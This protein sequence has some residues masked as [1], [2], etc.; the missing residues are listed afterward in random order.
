MCLVILPY[1]ANQANV[2]SQTCVHLQ[3]QTVLVKINVLR[4]TLCIKVCFFLVLSIKITIQV[5]VTYH[6]T[7]TKRKNKERHILRYEQRVLLQLYR[8]YFL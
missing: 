6:L 1:F 8:T 2:C 3:Q 4:G 7:E 5:V